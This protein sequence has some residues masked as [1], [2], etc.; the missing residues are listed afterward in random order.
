MRDS[1]PCARTPPPLVAPAVLPPVFLVDNLRRL[2]RY[3]Q[4]RLT[5]IPGRG[6]LFR[7][8][9]DHPASGCSHRT[10]SVRSC[11]KI[12]RK[13]ARQTEPSAPPLQ[14][15]HLLRWRR[16]F[17]LRS[18][19]LSRLLSESDAAIDRLPTHA[20]HHV[21]ARLGVL[22]YRSVVRRGRSRALRPIPW[23]ISVADQVVPARRRRSKGLTSWRKAGG[24]WIIGSQ[25]PAGI[26]ESE[27]QLKVEDSCDARFIDD[28]GANIIHDESASRN[29]L[30][31][32]LAYSD[33]YFARTQALF[34]GK[35]PH[36]SALMILPRQLA[37]GIGH[38]AV[39]HAPGVIHFALGKEGAQPL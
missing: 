16:R 14:A 34:C 3:L 38:P 35:K 20:V 18:V 26:F 28:G 17:R 15:S 19:I 10:A 7:Q 8:E 29:G 32:E 13:R 30:S 27:F 4:I 31:E 21:E 25:K 36:G 39:R 22:N 33:R 5:K 6:A 12:A 1:G 23:P 11:E 24:G 2:H 37:D 9:H